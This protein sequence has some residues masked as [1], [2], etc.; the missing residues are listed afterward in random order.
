MTIKDYIVFDIEADSLT[1]TK[2]HVLSYWKPSM[3]KPK[4]VFEYEEMLD[5]LNEHEYIIGHNIVNFDIPAIERICNGVVKSKPIDTLTLSWYAFPS[6]FRHGLDEWGERLGIP[7]PPVEDWE[8]LPLEVYVHRCESDVKINTNLWVLITKKL[9]VLYNGDFSV[10]LRWLMMKTNLMAIK[11]RNRVKFDVEGAKRLLEELIHLKSDKVTILEK[12]MPLVEKKGIMKKPSNLYKKDG[13]ISVM[14]RKWFERGGT[15][16]VDE[17]EYSKGF[18]RPNASSNAQIKDWLYSLGWKPKTFKFVRDKE[19]NEFRDIPQVF[20]KDEEGNSILC[21]SVVQLKNKSR[22]VEALDDLTIISSRIAML[23]GWLKSEKNST[24][25]AGVHGL[26]NT[27]RFRHKELVNIPSKRSKWGKEIRSLLVARDG[28]VLC[29]SDLSAIESKT[30]E[31]FIYPIDPEY[32]REMN[33]KGFDSHLDIAVRSGLMTQDEA[34]F[35]KWYKNK[36]K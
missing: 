15:D 24:L 19:T 1:P 29:G 35:Y 23:E 20:T 6:E 32:V 25:V 9:K 8:N 16:E 33:V 21:P 17:I 11:D 4:S 10:I 13:E 5:I 14:G 7:K 2:I 28:Y 31:H 27:L 34:D 30:K 22:A 36:S 26:T 12:A 3:E 18:D